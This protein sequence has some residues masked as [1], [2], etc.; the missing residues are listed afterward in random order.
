MIY[1]MIGKKRFYPF[2]LPHDAMLVGEKFVFD[3]AWYNV[4]YERMMS[5]AN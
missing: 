4:Q 2:L 5:L 3:G 1:F